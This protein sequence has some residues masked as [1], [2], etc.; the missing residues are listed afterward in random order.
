[1]ATPSRMP[2]YTIRNEGAGPFAVFACEKCHREIRSQPAK[3]DNPAFAQQAEQAAGGLLRNIPVVGD[4]LATT[5]TAAVDAMASNLAQKGNDLLGGL[6]HKIP[7]VGDSM[8]TSLAANDPRRAQTMTPQQ[9]A[10]AWQEVQGSFRE[11]PTCHQI[12]CTSDFDDASGFCNDHRPGA[13]PGQAAAYGA[14]AAPA[15]SYG[16]GYNQPAPTQGYGTP[17]PTSGYGSYGS[18]PEPA[19]APAAAGPMARCP[20][21]GTEA[22]AGTKFCP[23]CGTAMVQPAPVVAVEKCPN[24]GTELH[25]AKFCP[26]CGT[27]IE[28]PAAA[29]A[30][31]PSCGAETKGAKFCPNCGTKLI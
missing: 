24:C 29:P 2:Q 28:P 17:A 16:Y 12:V 8:A 26:N 21:D 3:P 18:A 1:M 22:P 5:T 20:K 13:Q 4:N 15:A 23:N 11:C 25:G 7:V 14:A 10:L 6:L 30:V 31:C 19:P 9:L 27:K